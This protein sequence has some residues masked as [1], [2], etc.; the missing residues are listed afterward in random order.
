M[1]TCARALLV[2]LS[3][4][5]I[6]LFQVCYNS[7]RLS[8]K[9]N[10]NGT[11]SYLSYNS[12]YACDDLCLVLT[13]DRDPHPSHVSGPQQA[14]GYRV[15][16]VPVTAAGLRKV[17]WTQDHPQSHCF[18][19]PS[20][21]PCFAQDPISLLRAV[22]QRIGMQHYPTEWTITYLPVPW[23]SHRKGACRFQGF[24]TSF[25]LPS[26]IH[27]SM[28]ACN[29]SSRPSIHPSI[30][31][32]ICQLILLFLYLMYILATMVWVWV[33]MWVKTT[34]TAIQ[35]RT[36]FRTQE[37]TRFRLSSQA[38]R[39][40]EGIWHFSHVWQTSALKNR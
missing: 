39:Q 15:K 5:C 16:R 34:N 29:P 30:H 8:V 2:A 27:S 4:L 13:T 33:W 11:G 25:I 40:A 31:P 6:H 24:I 37:R 9:V 17:S 36:Y 35:A 21:W 23:K 19:V 14:M 7:P 32:S 20:C 12:Y 22:V 38:L 3:S 1:S 28:R 10:L 18:L 26:C